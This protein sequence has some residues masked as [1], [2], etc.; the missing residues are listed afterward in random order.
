M[1][2]FRYHQAHSSLPEVNLVPMMDA[3]LAV[4]AFFITVA[5][6]FGRFQTLVV[7][8]PAAEGAIVPTNL[9]APLVV[10]LQPG[11][12]V[13][14]NK[15]LINQDQLITAMRTY[16]ASYP[17]GN[18]LLQANPQVPYREVI[19]LLGVMQDV[20]GDRVLLAIE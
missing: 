12:E 1:V 8:L 16:L 4:L 3:M 6:L 13:L 15:Q 18:V 19:Q 17:Q 5:M 11:D 7:Q 2:Q 10:T 14:L 9:P 20:G